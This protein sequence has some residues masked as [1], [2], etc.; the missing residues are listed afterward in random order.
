[1]AEK[2]HTP[3]HQTA[4]VPDTGVPVGAAPLQPPQPEPSEVFRCRVRNPSQRAKV[5]YGGE[6]NNIA[7]HIPPG[8]TIDAILPDHLI[9]KLEEQEKIDPEEPGLHVEELGKVEPPPPQQSP[10]SQRRRRPGKSAEQ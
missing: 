1:M 9:D 10:A 5:I 6:W 4:P 2:E 8:A 7:Y 3:V